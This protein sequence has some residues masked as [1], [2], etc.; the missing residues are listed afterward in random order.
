MVR[1]VKVLS[2]DDIERSLKR[3]A[4]EVLEKNRGAQD[5]ILMGIMTRGVFLAKRLAALIESIEKVTVPVGE[6]DVGP[7]RDDGKKTDYCK[8]KV[9]FPIDGKIVVLVDDVLFTGRTVRAALGAL[10]DIGRPRMVQLA[11]LIDRGH[12]ELP[13]RPDFV[14]KNL[15]TSKN[16]ERVNVNLS[17][18]DGEDGVYIIHLEESV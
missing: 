13:I 10:S 7:Y 14:G 9:R 11:V 15:P 5:L 3:I 17:E 8:T 1:K 2:E 18:I 6:L 16:R 4:H 12:R